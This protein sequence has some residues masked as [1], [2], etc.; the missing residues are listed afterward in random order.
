MTQNTTIDD[1]EIDLAELFYGLWAHQF[2]LVFAP[3][4]RSFA[5]AHGSSVRKLILALEPLLQ[6]KSKVNFSSNMRFFRKIL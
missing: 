5:R 3:R 4:L 1:D 6:R 2:L